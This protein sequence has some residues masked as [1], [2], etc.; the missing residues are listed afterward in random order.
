MYNQ[1]QMRRL[2]A[3]AFWLTGMTNIVF[4][5]YGEAR[6]RK[7]PPALQSAIDRIA[8]DAVSPSM[9][10]S[11]DLQAARSPRELCSVPLIEMRV[12]NP[13]RFTLRQLPSGAYPNRMPRAVLPAPPCDPR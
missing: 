7:V 12:D 13:D 4:A 9:P 3:V 8:K 1:E 11:I 6:D 5:Q 10:K 2:I